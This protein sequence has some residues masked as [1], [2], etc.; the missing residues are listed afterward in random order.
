MIKLYSPAGAPR[1]YWECWDDGGGRWAIHQGVL[2]E[3]G[4]LDHVGRKGLRGPR[5]AAMALAAQK[6]A[7]GFA[8]IPD[9]AHRVV[10]VSL[11]VEGFGAAADLERRHALETLL[12]EI[13]GWTGLGHCDGGSIGSGSMEAFCLVVDADLGRRVIAEG[14]DGTQFAGARVE[15]TGA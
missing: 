6:R 13:L 8:E 15:E 10:Q 3:R 2:G 4:A 12:N 11:P 14:L 7:E 1:L 9:S 5:R